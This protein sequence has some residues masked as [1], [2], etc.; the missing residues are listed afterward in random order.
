MYLALPR[1]AAPWIA[2][3]IPAALPV[4]ATIALLLASRLLPWL[5]TASV[6]VVIGAAILAVAWRRSPGTSAPTTAFVGS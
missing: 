2:C 3:A 5:F 6:L 1:R 4:L